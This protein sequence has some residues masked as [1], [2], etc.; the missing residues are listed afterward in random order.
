MLGILPD[1]APDGVNKNFGFAQALAKKSLESLPADRNIRLV[2]SLT[3][4]LLPAEKGNIFQE[5]S[6]K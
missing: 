1:S 6:R 4:V 2:L 3:L 5:C